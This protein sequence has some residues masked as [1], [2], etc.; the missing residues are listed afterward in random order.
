MK[1]SVDRVARCLCAEQIRGMRRHICEW[2]HLILVVNQRARNY[3]RH[4]DVYRRA[5]SLQFQQ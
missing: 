3:Q 2:L 4:I 5:A 1:L